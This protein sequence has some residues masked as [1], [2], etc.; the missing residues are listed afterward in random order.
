VG[1]AC[2]D[3]VF[4][5]ELGSERGHLAL[6]EVGDLDRPLALG[7]MRHG[8]EHELE[9]RLLA[10]GIGDDLQTPALFEEQTFEQVRGA[11]R[12]PMGDRQAQVGDA[13]LEVVLEADDRAGQLLLIVSDKAIG[14]IAADLPTAGAL[15]FCG[16]VSP[17]LNIS[18]GVTPRLTASTSVT[19]D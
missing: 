18:D 3:L 1:E 5:I 13:G 16:T 2:L 10:E 4:L 8:G 9:N 7:G 15:Y 14:Q 17:N 11:R 19:F 12:P 6:F